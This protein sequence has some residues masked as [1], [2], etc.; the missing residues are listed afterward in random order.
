[1]SH[2][3]DEFSKS[4]AETTVPRRESLRLLGAAVAGA[5]LGPFGMK[6]AFGGAADPCK[7][8]CNGCPKSQRTRCLTACRACNNDPSRLCTDCWNYSCCD[9][10]ETC[11]GTICQNLGND[12]DHCGACYNLCRDPG[13]YENGACI[14]GRCEYW[15]V[16]GAVVCNGEC[17]LLDQDPKNCGACGNVCSSSTPVCINGT[18]SACNPL[19]TNCG[20]YC[21]YL[22]SDPRNCGACGNVCLSNSCSDGECDFGGPTAW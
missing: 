2:R 6:S 7:T 19:Q 21:A 3:F 20:G 16:A 13:P 4:L 8:F 9:S 22:D 15:C 18:C 10:G 12:F 1:M 17:S 5:F 11:C 14:S